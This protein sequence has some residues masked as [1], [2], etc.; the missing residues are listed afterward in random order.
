[1]LE[2]FQMQRF[3]GV[4]AMLAPAVRTQLNA[5]ALA[6]VRTQLVSV[7]GAPTGE[8]DKPRFDQVGD[9][10][11]V[12]IPIHHERGILDFVVAVDVDTRQVHGLFFLNPRLREQ[13][14][15]PAYADTTRFKEQQVLLTGD[16]PLSGVLAMPE[17]DGP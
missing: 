7:F 2:H 15:P 14:P 1:L 5:E 16:L 10:H 11:R 13:A 8:R 6:G 3:D 12:T 9:L 4:V 17:G